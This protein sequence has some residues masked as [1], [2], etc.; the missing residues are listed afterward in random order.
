M[1]SINFAARE[2][3]VKIC[4]FGAGEGKR[5]NLRIIHQKIP[6]E[7]KSD[8]VSLNTEDDDTLFFDCL[9]LDLGKIKGFSA[10]F[11]LYTVPMPIYFNATRKLVMRG[12][13]GIVF[14]TESAEKQIDLNINA[15]E[16]LKDTINEYGYNFEKIPFV[17]QVNHV[18]GT[19]QLSVN[20][21]LNYLQAGNCPVME[22]DTAKGIGVFE[23][24]NFIGKIIIANLK[25][26][27]SRP[28]L[29]Q[30]LPISR[31]LNIR[32]PQPLLQVPQ[33]AF[34]KQ[35]KLSKID[36]TPFGSLIQIDLTL[37]FFGRING[38]LRGIMSTPIGKD[39][40]GKPSMSGRSIRYHWKL[41]YDCGI[42][43]AISVFE[44]STYPD[45][46]DLLPYGPATIFVFYADLMNSEEM[47]RT[48]QNMHQ[49]GYNASSIIMCVN[50]N[51]MND[52][53]ILCQGYSRLTLLENSDFYNHN[54]SVFNGK[55]RNACLNSISDQ[56]RIIS[57]PGF[58]SFRSSL[59]N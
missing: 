12:V 59:S 41:A 25:R 19:Q 48:L 49:V 9:L 7:Y 6:L 42:Q 44:C 47:R 1:A 34:L 30:Q 52:I 29:K 33:P 5:E 23:T 54:S 24:V 18:E 39:D 8:I 43:V 35:F 20:E 4:Y 40:V 31:S 15:Y 45:V 46:Y 22:A 38:G 55:I 51:L 14:V 58:T 16:N 13:D 32:S 2:I 36:Y 11:G 3:S 53:K 17:L 50:G 21:I 56:C 27:Y 28:N 26:K 37:V 57:K 10:K